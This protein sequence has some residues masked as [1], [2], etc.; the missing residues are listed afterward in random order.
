M[1]PS[2]PLKPYI[3]RGISYK[4][5]PSSGMGGGMLTTK[6]LL[7]YRWPISNKLVISKFSFD[8]L[9]DKKVHLSGGGIDALCQFLIH[10]KVTRTCNYQ[11]NKPPS[12]IRQSS[13][14][15]KLI[16]LWGII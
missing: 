14:H 5:F 7:S 16:H 12:K 9:G 15:K 13:L 4:V 8:A 11:S 10:R 1:L 2:F 3:P 6:F